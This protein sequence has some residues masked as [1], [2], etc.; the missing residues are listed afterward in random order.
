MQAIATKELRSRMRGGRAFGVLTVYL[1]LL[2]CLVVV[3]YGFTA[4]TIANP[5]PFD[6]GGPPPPLGKI[7]FYGVTL[8]ELLLIA[9]LA[10]SFTAGAI[11][12]ERERQTFDLVMTTPIRGRDFVLGK[13]ASGISYVLL[14][15]FVALPVQVLA[16]LFGG[17]T[18][19]ELLLGF[20][21]LIVATVFYA[22][23][24][25]FFSSVM[26]TTT[27]ASLFSYIVVAMSLIGALFVALISSIIGIGGPL[28]IFFE[29]PPDQA[30]PKT[31]AVYLA[32][33]LVSLSPLT[34]GGLTAVALNTG[35][36]TFWFRLGEGEGI[37][38]HPN[39][40]FIVSPWLVYSVIYLG[41]SALVIFLSMRYVRPTTARN[42]NNPSR[43]PVLREEGL[44]PPPPPRR[45]DLP[46]SAAQEGT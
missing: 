9:P 16:L 20:W 23:V 10:P 27:T 41:L 15:I 39:G 8:V 32:L 42:P 18:L 1:L 17:L 29:G 6:A 28:G 40:Y 22:S 21:T 45:V 2:S 25:L 13:L 34:A 11:A 30:A 35:E 24:S 14:L 3:I 38:G 26:K 43:P 4:R 12:G 31:W 7:L 33:L 5:N 37:P 36:G 46:P 44:P 19:T